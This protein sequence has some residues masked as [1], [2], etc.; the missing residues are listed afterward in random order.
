MNKHRPLAALALSALGWLLAGACNDVT[1]VSGPCSKASDCIL[2]YVC[3]RTPRLPDDR[4]PP[5]CE[6]QRS[7]LDAM[8][9]LVEG[10]PCGRL[11][12]PPQRGQGGAPA[13]EC[14]EGLSCCAATLTCVKDGAC[15][16][17]A[18]SS[19]ATPSG[20]PCNGDS[21]CPSAEICC[22][23]NFNNRN[24]NCRPVSQCNPPPQ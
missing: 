6:E 15:P 9:F 23:I 14:S 21:D 18:P 7:C 22:G 17:P 19:S 1:V 16:G 13:S 3:C 10:N 2:P 4:S 8:P 20:A 11:P 5:Y 12:Q 24:G